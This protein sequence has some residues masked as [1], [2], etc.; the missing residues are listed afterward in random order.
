MSTVLI[1]GASRGIG[2]EFARQYREAGWTVYGTHRSE[3][4]RIKLRD[5]GVQRDRRKST[6]P[7]FDYSSNAFGLSAQASF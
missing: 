3:D 5:L 6:E 4:D 2:F 7:G 1:V